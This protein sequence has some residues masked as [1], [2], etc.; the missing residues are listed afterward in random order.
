MSS[1]TPTKYARTATSEYWLISYAM[2]GTHGDGPMQWFPA[3]TSSETEA[4]AHKHAKWLWGQI[5]YDCIR[6]TG[7]HKQ[8]IPMSRLVK[9]HFA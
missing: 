7:P 9:E 1:D 2:Y 3:A 5:N 4:G 6:V 8:E